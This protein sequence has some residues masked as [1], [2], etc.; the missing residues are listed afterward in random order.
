M[1]C[2]KKPYFNTIE[3]YVNILQR[4]NFMEKNKYIA[5]L[6]IKRE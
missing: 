1:H 4:S 3:V 5:D 2:S 6:E